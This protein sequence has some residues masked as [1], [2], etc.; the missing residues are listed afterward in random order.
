MLCHRDYTE[1]V[2]ASFAHQIQ[3]EY[4]GGNLSVSIKGI[5]LKHFSATTHNETETT[6]QACTRHDVFQF[7]SNDSKQHYATTIAHIKRIITL[8]NQR[9]IMPSTLSTIF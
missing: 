5:S 9:N 1:R 8:L 6:P 7:F 4:N 2:V 3:S